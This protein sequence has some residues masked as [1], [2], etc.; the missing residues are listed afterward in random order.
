MT[1]KKNLWAELGVWA[2]WISSKGGVTSDSSFLTLESQKLNR[3]VPRRRMRKVEGSRGENTGVDTD[4]QPCTKSVSRGDVG[5]ERESLDRTG[6]KYY[7]EWP[8]CKRDTYYDLHQWFSKCDL[9]SVASAPPGNLL[10]MQ[11]IWSHLWPTEL[12]ILGVRSSNLWCN[13][14]SRWF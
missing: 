2:F 4:F 5:L 1:K 14:P 13:K 7:T 3:T 11:I 6:M 10:A 9:W 8:L 12:E